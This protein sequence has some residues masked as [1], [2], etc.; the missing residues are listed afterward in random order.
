MANCGGLPGHQDKPLS[1]PPVETQLTTPRLVL[2]AVTEADAPRIEECCSHREMARMM[3]RVPHPYPPGAALEFVQGARRRWEKGE[4]YTFVGQERS[5]GLIVVCAGLEMAPEHQHA[6]LGYWV[7]MDH[8][9]RGFATEAGGAVVQFAFELLGLHRVHAGYYSHNPA[10]GRVLEKLGFRY[11]GMRPGH[12]R[13][14]DQFVDL[15]LVGMLRADW[16][17]RGGGTVR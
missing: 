10:S 11:E 16:E 2:R 5:I 8:W 14:L 9:G 4:G 12:I 7:A 6:E 1:I 3:L 15:A 13:R 17:A